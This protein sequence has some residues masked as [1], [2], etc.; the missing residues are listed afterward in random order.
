MSVHGVRVEREAVSYTHLVGDD[1]GDFE[2]TAKKNDHYYYT[3]YAY[4]VD[5]DGAYTLDESLSLIHI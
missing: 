5:K 1:A 2:A 4:T 3:V